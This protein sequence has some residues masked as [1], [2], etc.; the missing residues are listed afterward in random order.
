MTTT[1]L[2]RN[3][4][5]IENKTS[6]AS[7]LVITSALNNKNRHAESYLFDFSGL[8]KKADYRAKILNIEAK[9]LTTID[10]N[11]LVGEIPDTKFKK[12]IATNSDLS[13]VPQHTKRNR[14]KLEKLQ[15]LDLSY[16]LDKSLFVDDN[17]QNMFFYLQRLNL[18]ELKE[19]KGT[20]HV[21]VGN[22]KVYIVLNSF[23]YILFSC[24]T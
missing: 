13:T 16:F 8:V 6:D 10:Y 5:R 17:F 12:K 3:R 2:D 9:Y 24:I 1:V 4:G 23:H 18:L 14:E 20:D 7:G 11:K 15:T 21:M 19:D 22:Q